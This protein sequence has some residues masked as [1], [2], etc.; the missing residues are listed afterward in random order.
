MCSHYAAVYQAVCFPLVWDPHLQRSTDVQIR[1][2]SQYTR[3]VD[4]LLPTAG[5]IY[6]ICQQILQDHKV[7][8]LLFEWLCLHWLSW[9]QPWGNTE[10]PS[11]LL[12]YEQ[13]N[14]THSDISQE[15]VIQALEGVIC[16]S[17]FRN[18]DFHPGLQS[19]TQ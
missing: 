19:H 2:S 17:G 8:R 9:K 16:A 5:S 15:S 7:G 18:A 14:V 6:G 10:T 11:P 1:T 4:P 3:I 13:C 12:V